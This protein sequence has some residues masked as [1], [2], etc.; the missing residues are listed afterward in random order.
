MCVVGFN[1]IRGNCGGLL[2]HYIPPGP[3]EFPE[4]HFG[5]RRSFSLITQ[6]VEQVLPELVTE[7]EDGYKAVRYN[8]LP[9][10][11]TQAIGERKAEKDVEIENLRSEIAQLQAM[12]ELL[13]QRLGVEVSQ[14]RR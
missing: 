13:Q 1:G 7:D 8:K 2:L 9:L 4:K 3:A 6:G 11:N 14:S 10:L 5:K 12:V